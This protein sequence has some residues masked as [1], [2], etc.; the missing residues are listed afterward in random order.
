MLQWLGHSC[1]S[2]T[3]CD[4][5]PVV[6]KFTCPSNSRCDAIPGVAKFTYI[7]PRKAETCACART[8]MSVLQWLGHSCPSAPIG[9]MPT[10]RTGLGTDRNV[11]ATVAW[12]F[13]SKRTR[14]RDADATHGVGHGQ[15]CPSY[16]GWDI[17]VQAIPGATPFLASQGSPT[18]ATQGNA[19]APCA[20]TGVSVLQW[21]GHSCPS[22]LRCDDIPV[23]ARF[24][25]RRHTRQK[26]APYARTGVSVLQW[27]GHSCPSIIWQGRRRYT[28]RRQ[29]WRRTCA[30]RR[31][32][33][34][35]YGVGSSSAGRRRYG[36][37]VLLRRQE[38]RRTCAGRRRDADA[39]GLGCRC[40]ARNGSALYLH[41][42]KNGVAPCLHDA[43]KGVAPDWRPVNSRTAPLSR[44]L[45][46]PHCLPHRLVERR[47]WLGGHSYLCVQICRPAQ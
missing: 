33:R 16:S 39:T 12:T 11:R 34:R 47:E 7:T 40:D 22:N 30:G 14:R 2:P 21:L 10:L 45:A 32:G 19:P 37:R 23:V 46:S 29:E 35:R 44:N 38:W 9:G 18:D 6:A 3:R 5:I 15:E 28:L 24:T 27:L 41:D 42:A 31:R 20:R 4:A 8:G 26:P 43:T 1:P 13:L 36:V 25:N 17:P